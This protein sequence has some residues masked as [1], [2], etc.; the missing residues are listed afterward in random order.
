MTDLVELADIRAAR[1]RIADAVR[2]TPM[3]P[4]RPAHS[5]PF[6]VDADL[7][8]KLECLQ[9]TGSFKA[10]GACSKLG[11]LDPDELAAGVVTAS[12]GNH[13]AAVAYAAARAAVPA[14]VYL[15]RTTPAARV[16]ALRRA[17]AIAVVEGDA[18]DDANAAA[19]EFAHRRGATYVHPFADPAVIAGQGTLGLEMLDEVPGVETVIVAIGGGGLVAGVGTALRMLK[20]NV[21]IVG[22]EPTGAPTLFRSL[23]AGHLVTLDRIETGA[24]SLAPRRSMAINLEIAARTVDKVVLVSDMEMIEAARWLWREFGIAVELAGAASLAALMAGRY[25]PDPGESVVAVVCG[26]G[27]DGFA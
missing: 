6:L 18:W 10:R 27:T 11:L 20:P 2:R 25:V 21:R 9:V 19:L 26:A 24:G 15:P 14:T 16:E 7:R 1:T 13:G 12:G 5:A 4:A 17:G 22:V 3:M 8:F 23:K